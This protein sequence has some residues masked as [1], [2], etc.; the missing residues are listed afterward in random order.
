MVQKFGELLFESKSTPVCN[1]DERKQVVEDLAKETEAKIKNGK[2]DFTKNNE[3]T[4]SEQIDLYIQDA[5]I[6][7]HKAADMKIER[8]VAE[9]EF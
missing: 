7:H 1:H 3:K 9:A 8:E 4:L 5:T 2:Y 6:S